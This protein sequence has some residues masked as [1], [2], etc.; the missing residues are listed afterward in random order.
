MTFRATF[1]DASVDDGGDDSDGFRAW[2]DGTLVFA[3]EVLDIEFVL[4]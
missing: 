1:S 2:S 4:F 3:G